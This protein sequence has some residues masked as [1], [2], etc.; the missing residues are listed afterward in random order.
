MSAIKRLK[1]IK[2]Q[3]LLFLFSLHFLF[4]SNQTCKNKSILQNNP[5]QTQTQL[6]WFRNLSLIIYKTKKII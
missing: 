3:Y 5:N 6:G 4:F 2:N 1:K